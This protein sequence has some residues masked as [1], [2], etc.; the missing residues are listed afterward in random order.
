MVFAPMCAN[1][2]NF[3]AALETFKQQATLT[4]CAPSGAVVR[5]IGS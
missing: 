2:K 1:G 3:F 5:Q 4:L